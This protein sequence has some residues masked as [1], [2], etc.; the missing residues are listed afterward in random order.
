MVAQSP[1]GRTRCAGTGSASAAPN[2]PSGNSLSAP[3]IQAQVQEGETKPTSRG[4][5]KG[6]VNPKVK[7]SERGH[8][9]V[10]GSEKENTHRSTSQKDQSQD[11]QRESKSKGEQKPSQFLTGADI[12]KLKLSGNSEL[13]SP[14]LS[15]GGPSQLREPLRVG[16]IW[17]KDGLNLNL[18]RA[19]SIES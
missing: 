9:N 10:N 4:E 19:S 18:R 17:V 12:G 1:S 5:S 8:V 6:D 14:N 16:H 15:L 11:L 3:Q 7:D 2:T 13:S